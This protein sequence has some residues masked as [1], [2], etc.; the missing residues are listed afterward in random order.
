MSYMGLF[1]CFRVCMARSSLSIKVTG[2][3]YHARLGQWDAFL[4]MWGMAR[5]HL[6]YYSMQGVK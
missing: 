3:D 6:D 4:M 5:K 2:A 1:E